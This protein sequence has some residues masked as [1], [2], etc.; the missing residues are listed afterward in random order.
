MSLKIEQGEELS[1]ARGMA[2]RSDSILVGDHHAMNCCV[3]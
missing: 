1:R 3:F 2:D